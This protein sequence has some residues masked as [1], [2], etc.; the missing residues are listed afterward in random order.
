MT[1][2]KIPVRLLNSKTDPEEC[3]LSVAKSETLLKRAELLLKRGRLVAEPE[4]AS[5]IQRLMMKEKLYIALHD[6]GNRRGYLRG[7]EEGEVVVRLV[8][9]MGEVQAFADDVCKA[10]RRVAA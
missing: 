10:T 1:V 7:R 4:L 2:P 3:R 5:L 8:T 9:M 6:A